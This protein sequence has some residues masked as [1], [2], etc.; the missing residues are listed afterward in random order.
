VW[1]VNTIH[2]LRDPA[3]G[4]CGMAELLRPGGR[5]ALGQ[6]S[7]LPD[8][9]FAWDARLERATTEAVRA[10]YRDRYGLSEQDLTAVRGC[11]DCY[12]APACPASRPGRS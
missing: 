9:Y 1:S 4:A 5:L 12:R 7:L 8:M 10:Y 3:A 11:W 2:H 6:S